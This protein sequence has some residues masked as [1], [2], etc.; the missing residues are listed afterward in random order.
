M[1]TRRAMLSA[2]PA[3]AATPAIGGPTTEPPNSQVRR[4]ML[5]QHRANLQLGSNSTVADQP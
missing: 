3:L 5:R 1:T 2:L 4:T